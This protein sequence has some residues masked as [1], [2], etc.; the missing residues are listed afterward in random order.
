MYDINKYIYAYMY[1]NLRERMLTSHL[2][3]PKTMN[4]V[5]S[6]IY[7]KYV[8]LVLVPICGTELLKP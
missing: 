5:I 6:V 3:S 8:Y 4:S 2:F 7:N 1:T